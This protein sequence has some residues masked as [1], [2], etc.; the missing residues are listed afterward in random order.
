MLLVGIEQAVRHFP[1]YHKYTL[2]SEMRSQAMLVCRLVTRAWNDRVNAVKWLPG[3][4]EAVDDLKLQLQL[5]MELKVL[6]NFA[7]FEH[8][9]SLAVSVGKQC[10]GWLRRMRKGNAPA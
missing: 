4:V 5:G 7:E 1:R 9:S 6:R 10:G 2:G 8:L 3:L